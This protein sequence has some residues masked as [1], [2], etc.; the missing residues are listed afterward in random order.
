M[1]LSPLSYLPDHVLDHLFEK[2]NIE[3]LNELEGVVG[4]TRHARNNK[5]VIGGA[6]VDMLTKE[7]DRIIPTFHLPGAQ[8][9]AFTA[10]PGRSRR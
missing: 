4:D 3:I 9:P 6:W 5:V 10:C 2:G 7:L 8:L 1:K